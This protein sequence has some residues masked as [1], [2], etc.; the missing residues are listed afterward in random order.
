MKPITLSTILLFI[1]TIVA[2]VLFQF[3]LDAIGFSFVMT[4]I[5]LIFRVVNQ[6]MDR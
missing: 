2:G 1:F 3:N 4:S 6:Y 5:Y